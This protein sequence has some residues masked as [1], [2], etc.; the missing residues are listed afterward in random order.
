MRAQEAW[1]PGD[2]GT[3]AVGK[4]SNDPR[5]IWYTSVTGI[6]QSVW[7][8][9]V[10]EQYISNVKIT[11]DV[12][13]QKV[14]ISVSGEHLP[15]DFIVEVKALS[16]ENVI[17]ISTGLAKNELFIP[18][19]NPNLWS[20]GNPFLYDLEIVLRDESGNKIDEV[21]SYF[22]MRKISIGKVSDGYTRIL[23]NDKALFHLGPLD[24]GWWPD[25]LYTAPSDDALKYDIEV[26]K[27]LGTGLT[28]KNFHPFTAL[29]Q[30]MSKAKKIK[31]PAGLAS[32]AIQVYHLRLYRM[33]CQFIFGKPFR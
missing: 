33:Q 18:I 2:H 10:P 20:P 16:N 1:D 31:A 13:N 30:I 32:L 8:E 4:Q 5:G 29:T 17:G 12:D 14:R 11:P 24:Q 26:T 21:K 28:L 25:G 19:E 3:Q 23:L 22:G 15:D 7:L 9:Y 27:A 6:W